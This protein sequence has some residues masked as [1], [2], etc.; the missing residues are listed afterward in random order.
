MLPSPPL[1]WQRYIIPFHHKYLFAFGCRLSN[2]VPQLGKYTLARDEGAVKNDK[3][4]SAIFRKL[5]LRG[6]LFSNGMYSGLVKEGWDDPNELRE[7]YK[8]HGEKQERVIDG[9]FL[10]TSSVQPNF[11]EHVQLVRDHFLT[12]GAD[13][14]IE[15][16]LIREGKTRPGK[17]K[18]KEQ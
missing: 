15:F 18:G 13:P 7:A 6:G 12:T 3:Q 8:P 9:V 2:Y 14:I 16:P 11:V 1:V 10:V 17:D 5:Q 4:L